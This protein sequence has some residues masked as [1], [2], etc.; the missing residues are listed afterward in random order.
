MSTSTPRQFP[1][2]RAELRRTRRLPGTPEITT[3]I[4]IWT[5]GHRFRIQDGDGRRPAELVGDVTAVQ[6]FG[7]MPRTIEEFMDAAAAAARPHEVPTEIYGDLHTDV[8]EVHEP[9]MAPWVLPA[10][11][12]LPA[13]EQLF[14]P[15]E[16][17]SWR[18]A[19]TGSVLG[20]ET[21]VMESEMTGEEDG[22]TYETRFRWDVAGPFVLARNVNDAQSP[23]MRVSVE[24]VEMIEGE[25]EETEL[26]APDVVDRAS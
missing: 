7:L 11:D 23:G 10:T 8:A 25:V 12:L 26:L 2:L 17:G 4:V 24:V 5:D 15:L 3:T 16:T 20:R 21:Q 13:V 19:G 9:G 18:P 1:N 14:V 22:F 6:G